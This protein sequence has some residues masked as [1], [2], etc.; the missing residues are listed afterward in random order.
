MDVLV[1]SGAYDRLGKE[2]VLG[3]F[4]EAAVRAWELLDESAPGVVREDLGME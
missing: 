2:S 4:R 3:S 1:R